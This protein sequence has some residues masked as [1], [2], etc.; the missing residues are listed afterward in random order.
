MALASLAANDD[1]TGSG[2]LFNDGGRAAAGF[3][4][5]AGDCVC[6]A[7]AITAGLPYR[8]VYEALA[9]GRGN[10]RASKRSGR[11]SRSAREGINTSRKWFRD[12]MASLGFTWVPTMHVGQGCKVHLCAEELPGGR[13]IAR[14][15][16]HLTA[17]L[18]GVIHDTYD[19][20]R[21]VHCTRPND[22]TPLKPGER[23]NPGNGLVCWVE[24]RC[25]YGYWRF[26]GEVR[27]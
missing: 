19:P 14:V 6:R 24:R 5:S 8:E 27:S 23:I 21:D 7:I 11:K 4:G 26:D 13:I 15:T 2:F 16:K 17:V 22:G 18:D 10:Q 9:E 25:V 3:K 20:R 12:Y 1:T